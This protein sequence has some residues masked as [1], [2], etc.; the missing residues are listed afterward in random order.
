M[1]CMRCC[2]WRSSRCCSWCYRMCLPPSSPKAA[3]CIICSP[4]IWP[5]GVPD[6]R[7]R[8][9]DRRCRGAGRRQAAIGCSADS[10]R[11]LGG[12]LPGGGGTRHRRHE[13]PA[14]PGRNTPDPL[15][16][17]RRRTLASGVGTMAG[18]D[19]WASVQQP[20][21]VARYRSVD[22]A[23]H[24]RLFLMIQTRWPRTH[25]RGRDG[26]HRHRQPI[27]VIEP[28]PP[29]D[30]QLQHPASDPFGTAPANVGLP[31]GL[32]SGIALRTVSPSGQSQQPSEGRGSRQTIVG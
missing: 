4:S 9:S 24:H 29:P 28:D 13:E 18:A 26:P 19:P 17:V 7:T 8:H 32:R 12:C 15:P 27:A 25:P 6:C 3:N 16:G 30:D 20:A 2:Y 31:D 10:I 22:T 5:A 14:A 1:R 21:A 11:S 23:R